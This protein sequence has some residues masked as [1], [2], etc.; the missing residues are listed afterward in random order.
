MVSFQS[1]IAVRWKEWKRGSF[2]KPQHQKGESQENR[3]FPSNQNTRKVKGMKT[4][5]LDTSLSLFNPMKVSCTHLVPLAGVWYQPHTLC[6]YLVPFVGILYSPCTP[7]RW[8]ILMLYPLQV[9]CIHLIPLVGV[10][11]LPHTPSRCLV[12]ILYSLYV[13][14][15]C[16]VSLVGISYL[17]C[18]PCRCLI[19]SSYHL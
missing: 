1:K 8:L 15:T 12:P 6:G 11:H 16:L 5:D 17:P 9:F 3:G 7:C 14:Y 4:G 13:P 10:L 19:P 2:F 18:T